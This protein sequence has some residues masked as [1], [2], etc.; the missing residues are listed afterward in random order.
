M[1]DWGE[2]NGDQ[3]VRLVF[4]NE[5]VKRLEELRARVTRALVR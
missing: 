5:P 2:K 3:L 4:S 1:K